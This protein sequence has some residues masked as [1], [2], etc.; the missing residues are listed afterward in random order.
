MEMASFLI[1]SL[2]SVTIFSGNT[3]LF[4]SW[5]ETVEN[6]NLILLST[7]RRS[8]SISTIPLLL[9][10]CECLAR[11]IEVPE[12]A[13][14]VTKRRERTGIMNL[15]ERYIPQ[16]EWELVGSKRVGKASRQTTTNEHLYGHRR[17]ARAAN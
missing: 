10:T 14:V 13:G 5:M 6:G 4:D 12:R 8:I 1:G 11:G 2:I 17:F 16:C 7:L 3:R 9:R 15:V